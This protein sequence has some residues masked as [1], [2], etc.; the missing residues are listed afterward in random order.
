MTGFMM[1]HDAGWVVDLAVPPSL[2]DNTADADRLQKEILRKTGIGPVAI[3]LALLRELPAR[4]NNWGYR[5]R[6]V[7]LKVPAGLA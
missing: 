1:D 2:H 3:D 4:L 5:C 7:F 6:C